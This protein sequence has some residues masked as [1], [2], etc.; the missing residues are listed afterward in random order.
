MTCPKC[1]KE[2]EEG[3]GVCPYCGAVPE[4]AFV[5]LGDE[6]QETAA[7]AAAAA[8]KSKKK[9]I[10]IIV[11]IILILL[12]IPIV[13]LILVGL[14]LLLIFVIIPLITGLFAAGGTEAN[15]DALQTVPTYSY[16]AEVEETT[17]PVESQFGYG[18]PYD[19]CFQKYADYVLPDSSSRYLS[20][21]DLEGLSDEELE[22]ALKEIAARRGESFTDSYIQEYFNARSWYTP[23]NGS[24]SNDYEK[25]NENLLNVYIAM[26]EGTLYR[27][28]N[29]YMTLFPDYQDYAV[30]GSESRYVRADDLKTLTKEQLV[31]ARN[32]LY[33]RRGCI[34]GADDLQDYFYTKSWYVP[35]IQLKDFKA[36]DFNDFEESNLDVIQLYEKRLEGVT[37]SKDNP[38]KEIFNTQQSYYGYEYI[39]NKNGV[40]LSTTYME[41]TEKDLLGLSMEQVAIARNEIYARYGYSFTSDNY[42][43]YFLQTDW[44]FPDSPYGDTDSLAFTETEKKNIDLMKAREKFLK[45]YGT[46]A[47]QTYKESDMVYVMNGYCYHI[48]QV[49]MSGVSKKSKI[50]EALKDTYFKIVQK[51]VFKKDVEDVTLLGMTY[52]VGKQGDV[53][54]ITIR[55]MFDYDQDTYTVEYYSASSGKKLSAT[56]VYS[57][58]GMS[59]DQGRTTLLQALANCWTKMYSY[60]NDPFYLQ[61]E[62]KTLADE[63]LSKIYPLISANG[64]LQ[65]VG[66]IYSM[67]GADYYE[68]RFK[69]N[70]YTVQMNCSG[71]Y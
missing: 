50:N 64:D 61:Q 35:R 46:A 23:G 2:I 54:T 65:F 45:D 29:P 41:L 12:A 6:Q 36:S 33:A 8:K 28:D 3:K 58:F 70:G 11:S 19:E 31:I 27:F 7:A 49:T 32:E 53:V 48:P 56:D 42:Q 38:Y 39:K 26:Q 30:S 13:L 21:K 20:H 10:I 44:Y 14:I 51:Q 15:M 69:Q 52:E 71:H 66:R 22:I 68:Y 63:N 18:N 57:A 40:T 17:E 1:G 62:E 55:Q 47:Q 4:S 34:F 60:S 16:E 67:A 5:D 25:A 24:K 59:E 43:E 37:F 9:T